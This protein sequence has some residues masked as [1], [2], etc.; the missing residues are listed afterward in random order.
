MKICHV[1]EAAGAGT[2]QI[3]FDLARMQ[4][5]AGHDVTVIYAPHRAEPFFIQSLHS[6]A[7][8]H[9]LTTPMLRE[10][11]L[12]DLLHAVRLWRSLRQ[13][14]PFFDI[15][16]AHS[17]KAGAL[18]RLGRLFLPPCKIVYTPHGFATAA[19]SACYLFR[20]IE[21]FLSFFADA[22]IATSDSEK[23]HATSYIGIKEDKVH[24]I[25]NGTDTVVQAT[26]QEARTKLGL[27]QDSLIVGFVG[28]LA[29]EKNLPRLF[30]VIMLCLKERTD[31]QFVMLGSGDWLSYTQNTIAGRRIDKN[32]RL[33]SGLRARDYY[34]AFDVLINCSDHES[35][36]LNLIEAMAAGVPVV[37]TSVGI[38][39][40]AVIEGETGWLSSFEPA[41]LAQKLLKAIAL[42][43]E[44]R[45]RM[46]SSCLKH[47]TK[48]AVQEMGT[49][50]FS[51][52]TSLVS[53]QCS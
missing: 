27:S 50:T 45:D 23:H 22:I 51:L 6:I 13:H 10:V 25:W 17:S 29:K 16:H 46:C 11:G 48:F 44:E 39:N 7:G 32:V 12:Y 30:D 28:R 2:G 52:Y 34:P 21:W 40:E 31:L 38:A 18:V 36:G 20:L 42:S 4:V 47:I 9:I 24:V 33:F 14:K 8:L 3:V 5:E 1:V 37:T 15:L 19:V 41:E 35:F 53:R 26:R 49:K 43:P